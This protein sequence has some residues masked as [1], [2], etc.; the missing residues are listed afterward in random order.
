MSKNL[1]FLFVAVSLFVGCA[2]SKPELYSWQGYE[3]STYTY[4]KNA[5]EE[6]LE[7]LIL[8]YEKIIKEQKGTRKVA[9]PGIYADYGF[10][11][12]QNGE[13]EKGQEMLQKEIETYPES[14]IFIERILKMLE[15]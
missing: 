10:I 3:A 14:R 7:A 6:A 5:D 8:S 12:I 11:L 15:E 4:L 9:P 1:I 2:T 13:N